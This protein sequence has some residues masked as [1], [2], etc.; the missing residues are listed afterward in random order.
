MGQPQ[1]TI[2]VD[3]EEMKPERSVVVSMTSQDLREVWEGFMND[4]GEATIDVP[5]EEVKP[6]LLS[7]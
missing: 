3:F 4:M 2:D 1:D 6:K 7:E 5:H